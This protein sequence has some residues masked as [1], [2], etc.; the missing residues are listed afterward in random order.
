MR[1]ELFDLSAITYCIPLFLAR[2]AFD[3][4]RA[5]PAETLEKASADAA[6]R[7][8]LL[9]VGASELVAIHGSDADQSDAGFSSQM[10]L[11]EL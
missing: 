3:T 9:V 8:S 1:V 2:H 11:W 6:V 10:S 7:P 4:R 5:Q